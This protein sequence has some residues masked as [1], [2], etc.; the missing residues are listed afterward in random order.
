MPVCLASFATRTSDGW[1]PPFDEACLRR[2]A[3]SPVRLREPD[4]W[5]FPNPHTPG[6]LAQSAFAT[7]NCGSTRLQQ[8]CRIIL[9]GD[10]STP[11]ELLMSRGS[12]KKNKLDDSSSESSPLSTAHAKMQVSDVCAFSLCS[13]RT[14]KTPKA[15]DVKMLAALWVENCHQP[16][17][18][19]GYHK[20]MSFTYSEVFAHLPIDVRSAR[21][22]VKTSP[23]DVVFETRRTERRR[24]SKC[25][26]AVFHGIVVR[27]GYRFDNLLRLDL[28][29]GC[30]FVAGQMFLIP[31][32]IVTMRQ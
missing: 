30:P 32:I 22:E 3:K 8:Y 7:L 21:S 4:R 26:C 18:T 10:Q 11:S 9:S 14:G 29:C 17:H 27:A 15:A 31:H 28:K 24:A 13:W 23:V 19:A 16:G 12:S 5:R 1:N 2:G 20:Q 25:S 6:Q